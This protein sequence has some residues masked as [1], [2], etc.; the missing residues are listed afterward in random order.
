MTGR[1]L[2]MLLALLGCAS[3]TSGS[4][5]VEGVVRYDGR[6]QGPLRVAVFASFP[7]RGAP[8][9]E[10]TIE[11]PRYPQPY[12]VTGVP[13]GR[14]FVLAIV[15]ADVDDGDGYRPEVDAGGAFGGYDRPLAVTVESGRAENV[16]LTLLDPH[17]RSPW[18]YGR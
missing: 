9:A 8:L 6:V 10:V 2:G 1:T 11:N 3:G 5:A 12:A 16:D 4:A 7:P 17:A 13:P 15:D 14:V 18:S